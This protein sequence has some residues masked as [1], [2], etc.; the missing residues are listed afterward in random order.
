MCPEPLFYPLLAVFVGMAF[1]A[2]RIMFYP[3]LLGTGEKYFPYHSRTKDIPKE[4][5]LKVLTYNV[6]AF[7]YL[8]HTTESPNK[9][10]EYIAGSGADIVCLQEY[11]VSKSDKYLTSSK[12]Y[13]ALDMYPYRSVIPINKTSYADYGIAVF[14]KYPI[15]NSRKIKYKKAIAMLL[16]FMS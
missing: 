1:P 9:I 5:V 15:S 12:V 16:L 14:S 2:D 10:L 13:K 3:D 8:N 6:M 4:N 11:A 7:A